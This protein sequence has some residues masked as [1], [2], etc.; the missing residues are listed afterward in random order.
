MRWLEL[1]SGVG[2]GREGVKERVV[3][4]GSGRDVG[5][6]SGR[7]GGP[8]FCAAFNVQDRNTRVSEIGLCIL[9]LPSVYLTC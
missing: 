3:S 8:S 9:R 6:G 4:S 2:D 1:K 7:A 5:A